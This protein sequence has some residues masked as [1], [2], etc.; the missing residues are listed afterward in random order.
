MTLS[1]PEV[2]G[3]TSDVSC[4][5]PVRVADY[6]RLPASLS[7]SSGDGKVEFPS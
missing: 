1:S 6:V 4:H 7:E 3:E 2:V 5:G